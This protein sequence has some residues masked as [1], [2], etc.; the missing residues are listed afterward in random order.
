VGHPL[1]ET[2]SHGKALLIRYPFA[3]YLLDQ[4]NI[5]TISQYFNHL[6]NVFMIAH[7]LV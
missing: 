2:P 1:Q 4:D 6:Y 3:G 7:N 5:A